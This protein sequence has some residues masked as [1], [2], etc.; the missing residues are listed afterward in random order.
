MPKFRTSQKQNMHD[1]IKNRQSLFYECVET[2]FTVN[3]ALLI[4]KLDQ[5]DVDVGHRKDSLAESKAFPTL[6]NFPALFKLQQFLVNQMSFTESLIEIN[7]FLN[8]ASHL[9]EIIREIFGT[10]SGMRRSVD[11]ILGVSLLQK[12]YKKS[13]PTL[14]TESMNNL[15]SLHPFPSLKRTASS[16]EG[17]LLLSF[18]V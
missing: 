3:Y 9:T 11:R 12:R 15:P 7:L 5:S 14:R 6:A 4:L 10:P 16:R 13:Q 17:A 2:Y 18:R 8:D 1:P